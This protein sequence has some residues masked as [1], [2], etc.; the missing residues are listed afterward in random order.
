MSHTPISRREA[1]RRIYRAIL[2][3][4]AAS[5][6]SYRDLLAAASQAPDQ[7]PTLVWL[8][9]S[10]CSGCS[11]SFLDI[12]YVPVPDILTRFINLAFH[13]DLSLATG[14][15]V[16][17]VLER[18]LK[19][20]QPYLFVLEGAIPVELPHACLM[21]ERPI[22]EWVEALAGQAQACIAAGTCA[23]LGGV[24]KMRG[25]LTG[26]LTLDEFLAL[27]GLE[28]PVVNLPNCPMKPEH[29]VYTLLHWVK[30]GRPP[31]LDLQGRPLRFFAHTNHE[32]CHLYADFQEKHFATRVGEPGCLLKLG[33][34]GPVTRNDCLI[35]GHNGNTNSCIRAGHPCVGCASEHFP[36]QIL[37][38][39][40]DD[41]RVIKKVF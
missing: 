3:T 27:K 18:L 34:Q 9:G 24:P 37:F 38:H 28:R 15:Q 22:T 26:C 30:L 33:C 16:T 10:S 23:A 6:L 31:E 1:L 39:A 7:R 21:G 5:F 29:L 35:T 20:G 36:R 8:H 25:T 2:A 14:H 41:E 13:P 17:E 12:D 4:G 40:F 19:S 32:R 11:V